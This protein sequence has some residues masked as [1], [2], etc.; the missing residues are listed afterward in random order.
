V[1]RSNFIGE[2]RFFTLAMRLAID[3]SWDFGFKVTVWI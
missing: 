2:T 3:R 1:C